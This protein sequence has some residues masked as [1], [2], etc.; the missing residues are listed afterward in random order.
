MDPKATTAPD[1]STLF[2]CM[3]C[4]KSGISG[5]NP[6]AHTTANGRSMMKASCGTCNRGMARFVNKK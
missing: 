5:V 4:K 1:N 2:R 6:T 3:G